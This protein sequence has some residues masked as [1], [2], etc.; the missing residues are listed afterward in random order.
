M[1]IVIIIIKILF[2]ILLYEIIRSF[3]KRVLLRQ[4]SRLLRK[5][6][7]GYKVKLD[8]Y[9][10]MNKV[11]V[12]HELLNDNEIN[13]AII[14]YSKENGIMVEEAQSMVEKYIDEIV[15]FFNMLS[16]FK[17]GYWIA[18]IFLN[19]V[20]EV[21]IDRENAEKL[22]KIPR[23]NVVVFVMNHRSNIDYIIVSYM[24][25]RKISVSY[26]VGEWARIWPLEYIFKSFG[27]Y[28][29]RRNFK[30]RLYHIVLEKYIQ[31]ISLNGITQGIFPEGGLTRDGSLRDPKVGIIDYIINIKKD[32]NFTRDIVFI[33]VGINYDWVLEDKNL[34]SEWKNKKFKSGFK[35]HLLSLFKILLNTPVIIIT[36]IFRLISGKLK[37]H[38]YASVSFG[39]PVSV[40]AFLK[41]QNPRLLNIGR[42]KRLAVIKKFA[43]RLM[44][45]IGEIIPVT[46]VSITSRAILNIKKENF[47][48]NDLVKEIIQLRKELRIKKRRIVLGRA[49]ERGIKS[50]IN[51]KQEKKD[52]KKELVDF[53]EEFLE[54][55]IARNTVKAGL[56]ILKK[57]KIVILKKN[58]VM[59]NRKKEPLLEFYS[60]SLNNLF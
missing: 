34:V 1:N 8:R 11:I 21:V 44:N 35:D 57:R 28:F 5:L 20:Y 9:K 60:N 26:A 32:K 47:D 29:I 30:D 42:E 36:N 51:L 17:F 38:G 31:Q 39:D 55:G 46:P 40:S 7:S 56:E 10:F 19:M 37:Q 54:T 58:S 6:V 52:R 13:Q 43:A 59:I 12:K 18:G 15:P 33:P 41:K 27:A 25:A 4:Q 48:R 23:D 53:E 2:L 49:F 3:I 50:Q 22:K 16:Y 14:D 45:Q 24:L